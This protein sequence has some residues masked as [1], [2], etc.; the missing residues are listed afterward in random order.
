M[1]PRPGQLARRFDAQT[2][3]AQPPDAQ[4]GPEPP[5]HHHIRPLWRTP[6]ARSLL[7]LGVLVALAGLVSLLAHVYT[8]VLWFRELGHERAF[9]TTL[10]WQ[11]LGR[12]LP[13]FGTACFLIWNFA[14]V[15]RIVASHA[16]LRPHRR[17][18]YPAAAVLAGLI[19]LWLSAG[20]WQLLALW[21]GRSDFGVRDPVFHRDIGFYVFTLPLQEHIAR[22]LLETLVMGAAATVAAYAAAGRLRLARSHL[23]T[24]AALALLVLAWRSRLA[25]FAL[26]LPHRGSPVPGASYTD[27]HVRVPAHRALAVLALAGAALCLYAR[28]RPLPR[29]PTM[30]G[31]AAAVL[32][33]IGQSALP[34]VTERLDVAPQELT[35]ERPYVADA[36][37]STRRAFALD[38]VRVRG[39]PSDRRTS[40]SDIATAR[41]T[42]ASVPLWDADVLRPALD[43]LQSIGRYYRFAA[44]TDDRYDVNGAPRLLTVAARELDRSRLD[45]GWATE[46]FAY[47]HGYGAV[48]IRSGA[49]DPAG[50]PRFSDNEFRRSAGSLPLTEPR[51]YFGD[52][53][54]ARPSYIVVNTRRGEVDRPASGSRAPAYHYDGSGGIALSSLLRRAAFAA[55][56]GDFKLLLTETVTRESRIMIH[57][58][59]RDRVTML[60]PFL[61][62]DERPQTVI[63]GGRIQYVF[64]GYSTSS[65]YPYSA[66]VRVDGRDVNYLRAPAEAT[67]DAFTGHVSLYSL[68]DS[69]PILR[70]WRSAYPGLFQDARRMPPELRAHL[71]YP[72]GL[73]LAQAKVYATY[74][75][76]DPTAFWNGADAWQLPLQLAGPVEGA[77]E[78]HFPNPRQS[79]KDEGG[80]PARWKMRPGY[81]LARLPGQ[82]RERLLLTTPFTPRGRENLAGYLAGAVDAHG[83]PRLTLLSLPPDRMTLG[84]T[85]ATRRILASPRVSRRIEL[86]NRES[87]DLGGAAV[88]RTIV[89]DARSVPIGNALVHVQPIYVVAGGSGVPQLQVVT[90]S[91]DGRVAFGPDLATALRRAV[92]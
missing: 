57:R 37:A 22:W 11:A 3:P 15:E 91:V 10:K 54:S 13:A 23:F 9:W 75:A 2:G 80:L 63:A 28:R 38:E 70:A 36:I 30:I 66:P 29:V 62:W 16:P 83:R 51:V 71:R 68:D 88:S 14:G 42:I 4:I 50:H 5:P 90:V 53:R 40:A 76:V 79:V 52:G 33:V 39:L 82:T 43:E 34:S 59:A 87:R 81:L 20:T 24:L 69:E 84:P 49:V 60:A 44:T 56:F 72:P 17:L 26:A 65:W 74:H 85:Q 77:G 73:F 19:A 12:A 35:R 45:Q 8:D 32:I 31:A 27:V 61:H 48:A 47:T 78:I 55:R 21:A 18:A 89:G 1:A 7:A 25:E 86:L 67:V 6:R 58:S 92:E 46:R 64:H 41:R